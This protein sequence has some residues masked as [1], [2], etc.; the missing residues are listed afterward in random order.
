MARQGPNRSQAL[1]TEGEALERAGK[2]RD[3]VKLFVQAA[4]AEEEAGQPLRARILWEQVAGKAGLS[5]LVLERLA[6]S[7]EK[8]RLFD[9]AFDFWVGAVVR[10][11]VDGKADASK[12]ARERA[13]G[14]R[15]KTQ[16]HGRHPL[17]AAL[18]AGA[19]ADLLADL[20]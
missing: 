8:A 17:V 1:W 11:A 4:L 9:D 15:R 2:P 16:P 13:L 3:A 12:L 7:S 5:G 20:A 10:H 18:I 19:S 14:V 6:D